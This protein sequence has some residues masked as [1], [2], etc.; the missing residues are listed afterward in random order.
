ARIELENP[1]QVL[2]VGMYVNAAFGSLGNAESTVPVIPSSAVQN[3]DNRPLIFVATDEPNVF[4]L[5]YVRL[6]AEAN[7]KYIVLEGLNVGDKIVNDG[8]FS[9]RAEWLKQN[10][11]K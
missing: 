8:S 10:P 9:L 2:K 6:G 4:I 11:G 5:R 3:I 7:G 1:G